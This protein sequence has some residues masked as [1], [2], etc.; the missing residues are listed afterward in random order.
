MKEAK[1]VKEPLI[2]LSKRSDISKVKA[3]SIRIGA[4]LLAL[5]VCAILTAGLT[6]HFFGFFTNIFKGSFGN[7]TR[8]E[9]LIKNTVILLGIS[10]ALG[11]AFKMKFWNIGAEGQVL[12]G[13]LATAA[14]VHYFGG[15]LSNPVLILVMF[16]TSILAG[17]IWSVVPAVFKA[18]FGTNETL[19]TLMMNY[20]A[21]R[22][23]GYFINRW[24]PDGS[25]SMGNL[26]EGQLPS[27]FGSP[28]AI[29]IILILVI[30]IL[31]YLYMNY[32]KHGYELSVVGESLNT[33]KYVGIN[34]KLVI[35]RTMLLS[36]IICGVIGF[37]LVS[38]DQHT[39]TTVLVN[40]RGFTAILVAWLS[41]FNPIAMIL[42]SFIVCFLEQAGS[43]LVMVYDMGADA[44]SSILTGIFFLFIIGSTFFI[45][46]KV[47]INKKV[48]KA[49]VVAQSIEKE[50][51]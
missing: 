20:I 39:I 1:Q 5:L 4:G 2:H 35:I 30:T 37:L 11:P 7:L 31:I 22:L 21:M 27:L 32:S 14:C 17:A 36:G 48:K 26:S 41:Q 23:T 50:D 25:A 46:Y 9:K 51:K 10:V 38:G 44:Y 15:N 16:I 3:W 47:N 12:V 42:T 29:N 28:Y 45:N 34:V 33:A 40:S 6:G 24:V 43:E 49:P 18:F 8:F 13:A 19:F